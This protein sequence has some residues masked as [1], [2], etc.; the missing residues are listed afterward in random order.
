MKSGLTY[1]LINCI[2]AGIFSIPTIAFLTSDIPIISNQPEPFSIEVP[3]VVEAMDISV[4]SI[5]TE[6]IPEQ[7]EAVTEV[8]EGVEEADIIEDTKVNEEVPSIPHLKPN[9]HFEY[10]DVPLDY[11]LQDHIF[12]LCEDARIDP[13]IIIAMIERESMFT[14]DVI[15]DNGRAQGL[16]QVQERWHY[17]RMDE[18]GVTDLLDPYQ[19]VTIGIHFL[20]ELIWHGDGSLEWA[21]MAYNGGHGLAN[22]RTETV[23][24]YAETVMSRAEELK[25]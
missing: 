3:E 1:L 18:L 10:F 16:M 23:V 5:P 25:K 8:S 19:N 22:K 20:E 4:S 21:L 15:G 17:D 11:E 2:C 14:V 12:A 24:G 7:V 9:R 13:A 6:S